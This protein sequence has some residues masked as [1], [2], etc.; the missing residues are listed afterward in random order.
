MK[1]GSLSRCLSVQA[2]VYSELPVTKAALPAVP[3]PFTL[4]LEK[5]R[6]GLTGFIRV[7][8]WPGV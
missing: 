5:V 2:H 3:V 7:L 8:V 4:K 6:G 1:P